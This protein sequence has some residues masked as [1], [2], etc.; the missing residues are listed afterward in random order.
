MM[1]NEGIQAKRCSIELPP[2][3]MIISIMTR[4]LKAKGRAAQAQ[5]KS[6]NKVTSTAGNT[7]IIYSGSPA[8]SSL[9]F[10]GQPDLRSSPP[11][12]EGSEVDNLKGYLSWLIE[13][14]HLE[15]QLGMR[16]KQA[17]LTDGWGFGQLRDIKAQ[18]WAEMGVP[19]GAQVLLVHKQKEW[20]AWRESQTLI[21]AVDTCADD[22]A[23]QVADLSDLV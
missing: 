7:Y 22:S 17:L 12:L 16:V 20:M 6:L 21:A 14:K 11:R 15:L 19:R 1:W 8:V 23:V 13:K 9:A 10:S 4:R 3:A 2:A 5:I 18:D